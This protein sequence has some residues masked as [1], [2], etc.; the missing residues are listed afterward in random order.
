MLRILNPH[1]NLAHYKYAWIYAQRYN[2]ARFA[3]LMHPSSRRLPGASRDKN[4][5]SS[6]HKTFADRH[7]CVHDLRRPLI[8]CTHIT[9]R[10][11]RARALMRIPCAA[12]R[13][14]CAGRTHQISL[15]YANFTR[16]Q[17]KHRNTIRNP[18]W[19]PPPRDRRESRIPSI[20]LYN[21][22]RERAAQRPTLDSK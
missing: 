7:Y 15:D 12:G 6:T 4:I 11:P 5:A 10:W 8:V 22:H 17:N 9:C 1:R 3:Q 13:S 21:L 18:P 20:V 19:P 2:S 16:A 14:H